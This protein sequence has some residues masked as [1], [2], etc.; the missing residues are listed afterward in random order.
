M[1]HAGVCDPGALRQGE[2]L[3]AGQPP[4]QERHPLVADPAA[5]D[6][7]APQLVE[8]AAGGGGEGGEE[9]RNRRLGRV[10]SLWACRRNHHGMHAPMLS[11]PPT[12][13]RGG[14]DWTTAI[15][16]LSF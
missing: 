13:K 6:L 14:T 2:V 11:S 3:E 9:E 8:L 15:C 5:A 12:H 7:Q 4:R 10:V 1:S 16:N